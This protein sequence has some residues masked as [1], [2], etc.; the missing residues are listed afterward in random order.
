MPPNDA[1]T[2]M[3]NDSRAAHA[4]AWVAPS[5]EALQVQRPQYEVLEMLGRGSNALNLK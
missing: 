1:P 3:Q 5:V 2:A 4:G